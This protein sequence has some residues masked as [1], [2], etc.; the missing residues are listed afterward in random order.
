M[1]SSIVRSLRRYLPC[2]GLILMSVPA[3][4]QKAPSKPINLDRELARDVAP[5]RAASYYHFLL[6]KLAEDKNNLPEAISEMETA[7][8]YNPDSPSIHMDL[9]VLFEKSGNASEAIDHAQEAARLD[10]KN[11]DPHWLLANI[12][13]PRE[14]AS[15]GND[16]TMKAIQE[17]EK[18][19]ELS[20]EDERTYAALGEVYFKVNQPDK[21]I[22]AYEKYQ[23]LAED[24]DKGYLEIAKYYA[25]AGNLDKAVEYC[26][27]GLAAQPQS[28]ES[29]WFII[30]LYTKQNKDKEAIP[31]YKKLLEVTGNNPQIKRQLAVS[32]IEAGQSKDAVEILNELLKTNPKDKKIQILLG[33]AQIELR[34]IQEAIGLLQSVAQQDPKS[35]DGL[36]ARFYLGTAYERNGEFGEAATIFSSLL[37]SPGL[38]A[39]E[40]KAN[41][42]IFQQHL[43]ANYEELREYEKAI[44]VYQDI[45][46]TEPKMI[47]RLVNVYRLDR[48]FDKA[49]SLGKQNYDKNPDDIRI[50]IVYARTLGD[51]GRGKEGIEVLSKLLQSNP[52]EVDI[53]VN[54]SAIYLQDKR[55]SDAEKILRRGQGKKLDDEGDRD[56]LNLQLA[57]VY[58]KQKDFDRAESLLKEM[59]KAKPDNAVALNYIGYLLA[60]RGVRLEEAVRYVK[61]ALAIDPRNG[62]YLDSLGWAF[63]KLNDLG[64]A[65]KYLLEADKI[66]RNDSTIDEHLGDLYFK[67]GD[68]QKAQD[69]YKKSVSLGTEQ[70]EIEKVRRK[71]DTVQE[72]LRKKK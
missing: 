65:E 56:S 46:K 4:A 14:G 34:Q 10:P 51:A 39:D 66:S 36:E 27:K 40:E 42:I 23:T 63:F 6:S 62:A 70:D 24:T 54:M 57:S 35:Q 15:P 20:P 16:G 5:D 44:A 48:Q 17:L 29:L 59:L 33:R 22:Q 43:A 69:F 55:Y 61:E 25:N 49:L 31:I 19:R 47:S 53:Y 68:L 64:N 50:G 8:N 60:D 11:P 7:L 26:S 37:E 18:L 21:A 72:K 38:N 1:K 45:V 41:R 12:Y 52:S 2:L 13:Y 3:P 67:T 30:Q 9:A 71:L 28:A 58:E 32:L